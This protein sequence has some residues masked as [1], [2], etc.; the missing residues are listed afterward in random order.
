MDT[1][2]RRMKIASGELLSGS[3]I[4][5]SRWDVKQ[6]KISPGEPSAMGALSD[7]SLSEG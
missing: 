7:E 3:N 1:V 6:E 5:I 2:R 4:S